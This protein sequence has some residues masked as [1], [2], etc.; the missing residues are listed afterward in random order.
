MQTALDKGRERLEEAISEYTPNRIFAGFS[1]GTDSLMAT[2]LL[3][4]LRSDVGTL[5]VN[6]GIGM[7]RTRQYVR[8][9]SDQHGWDLKEYRATDYGYD[10]DEMV[11]GNVDGVPGG[12]PGPPLHYIY[13]GKLKE[14]PIQ[15]AHRDHKGKRGGKIALVTGIRKD[16]SEIRAG[17][18]DSVVDEL[19]GVVW[20][21]LIYEVTAKQ[22]QKY[23][24]LHG[25]NTNPVADVYGMSGECLCGAYDTGGGRL[26]ELKHACHKFDEPET[27]QRI[28]DLQDEVRERYPWDYDEERPEWYNKAKNGQ[29]AIK[30][31]PGAEEANDV[32]ERMC[33]GCGK[34][35]T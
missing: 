28:T 25:L 14:V 1:G 16:E 20:I 27:Y 8:E 34:S 31:L 30:G 10:Y 35:H 2:H 26:C 19:N 24:D 3:H 29:L 21:N 23:I 15:R 18:Q 6:T 22:K 4:Q 9:T 11:R 7:K 32:A 12:F 5:H 13:Y 17:Y 33:V